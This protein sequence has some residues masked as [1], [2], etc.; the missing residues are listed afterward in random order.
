MAVKGGS[1]VEAVEIANCLTGEQ[2]AVQADFLL[3]RIGV[4]PNT[5]LFSGQIELDEESYVVTD[6]IGMTTMDGIFAIGD[7]ANPHSPTI[8]GAVGGGATALKEIHRRLTRE[9][10]GQQLS[11]K[12]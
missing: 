6:F 12:T 1:T 3:I 2:S 11:R 9:A 4:I 7:V 5:E 8:S 10:P